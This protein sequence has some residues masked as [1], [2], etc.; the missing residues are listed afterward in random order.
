M[1]RG[2]CVFFGPEKSKAWTKNPG[3]THGKKTMP[4]VPVTAPIGTDSR[5]HDNKRT[6]GR[7]WNRLMRKF[8]DFVALPTAGGT[9][10]KNLF[11]KTVIIAASVTCLVLIASIPPVSAATVG[12]NLTITPR[13][14]FF[15]PNF[16]TGVS[17]SD[18]FVGTMFFDT[19]D[20][21][22]DGA[23]KRTILPGGDSLTIAGVSFD[24][25]LDST[26][27]SFSFAGGQPAC[28]DTGIGG[29]C[30]TGTSQINFE[31]AGDPYPSISFTDTFI[32][33]AFDADQRSMG[34]NYSIIAI[35]VPA[36]AYLMGTGLL[37]LAGVARRK[38]A[39]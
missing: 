7:A 20:L 26:F 33:T 28:F 9:D 13:V 15:D 4:V 17:A 24:A 22:P 27:W 10:M 8:L 39:D 5:S 29:A 23:R 6:R 38:S 1:M 12:I 11:S 3:K 21:T 31:N 14:G 2:V 25:L 16:G 35:P 19:G 36:A 18:S 34:F 32:G 37:L 30:G